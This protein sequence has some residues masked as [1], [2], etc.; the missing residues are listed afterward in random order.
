MIASRFG[1]VL[2]F[3]KVNKRV[4]LGC[5]KTQTRKQLSC[6]LVCNEN[7][8]PTAAPGA[9]NHGDEP[10]YSLRDSVAVAFR[11]ANAASCL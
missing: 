7:S 8:V 9:F 10:L 2:V 4:D 1:D 5:L 3:D 11:I 6:V